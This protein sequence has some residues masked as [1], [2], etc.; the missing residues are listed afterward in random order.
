MIDIMKKKYLV[1]N[2][3]FPTDPKNVTGN[4]MELETLLAEIKSILS[5]TKFDFVYLVGDLNCDFIRNTVHVNT[6]K[7]FMTT[8]N[9]LRQ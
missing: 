4:N 8:T 2:S 6:V 1:I 3:Y 7:D 9:F 5:S